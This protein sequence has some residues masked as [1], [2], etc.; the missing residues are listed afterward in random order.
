MYFRGKEKGKI[1][2]I[3]VSQ[4][5]PSPN[6]SLVKNSQCKVRHKDWKDQMSSGS[7]GV[8]AHPQGFLD[9]LPPQNSFK[10]CH[11]PS[12]FIALFFFSFL[13]C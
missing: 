3:P 5:H 8:D 7:G 6:C 12:F 2:R 10:C 11:S 13:K 1:V 4:E 9:G